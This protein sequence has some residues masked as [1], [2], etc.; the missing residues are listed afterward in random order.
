M[1]AQRTIT[2]KGDPIRNERTGTGAIT[3]GHLVELISTGNVQVHST[4]GGN[5]QRSFA[6]E[7]DLQ[8]N[9]ISE[10]YVTLNQVQYNVFNSGD[11]VNALLANG[12][13]AVIGSLLESAG[14]GT[15]QVHDPQAEAD[16]S[17]VT[18]LPSNII[19]QAIEAVDLSGSSA[20]D[21][22]ARILV[23]II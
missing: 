15:L 20:V 12:E 21:P 17:N 9:E 10:A 5:A 16:S 13:T 14:D 23:E 8:G 2:V 3:P 6:V 1:G 11:V 7:D 4:A 22:S 19:G 18:F